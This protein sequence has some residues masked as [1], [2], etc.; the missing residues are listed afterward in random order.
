MGVEFWGSKKTQESR[1]LITVP[2]SLLRPLEVCK[3]L[4]RIHPGMEK[5]GGGAWQAE[6][7]GSFTQQAPGKVLAKAWSLPGTGG[8]A[9]WRGDG[10]GEVREITHLH[11]FFP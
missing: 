9:G 7:G 5:V 1:S 2:F 11:S 8:C 10:K 6:P 4:Q 3:P